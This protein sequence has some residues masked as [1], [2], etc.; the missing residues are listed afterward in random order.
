[1]SFIDRAAE[2]MLHAGG[3]FTP[4]RLAA[5]MGITEHKAE[6]VLVKIHSDTKFETRTNG[7]P[8]Q[9]KYK[10]IS[11][12]G[13]GESKRITQLWNLALYNKPIRGVS[14]GIHCNA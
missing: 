7:Y 13:R 14:D 6:Q 1:M 2:E 3:Y 5:M 10:I 11:I 12:Q 8:S 4:P 9:R